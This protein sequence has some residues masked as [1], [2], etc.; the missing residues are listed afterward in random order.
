MSQ[1][2]KYQLLNREL[3]A[4]DP[5]QLG[6]N[7][8]ERER[9]TQMRRLSREAAPC[10]MRQLATLLTS[11]KPLVFLTGRAERAPRALGGRIEHIWCDGLMF[12]KALGSEPSSI[13][14]RSSAEMSACQA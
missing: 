12:T 10:S 14:V 2:T 3:V 9:H 7:P 8:F 6:S 11:N 13:E 1:D 4:D 5:W